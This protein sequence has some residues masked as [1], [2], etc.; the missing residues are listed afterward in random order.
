MTDRKFDV[1]GFSTLSGKR[2]V[3]FANGKAEVRTKVLE[4]NG[5]TDIDLRA[6]PNPMT[7]AEAMAFLGVKDEDETAPKG[8]QAAAAKA[9]RAAEPKV[10]KKVVVKEVKVKNKAP[11]DTPVAPAA[12]VE[13]EKATA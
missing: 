12:P 9:K 6:L 11:V 4:R 5:H 2:K 7:K 8:V 13:D 10:T 1:A 3:R